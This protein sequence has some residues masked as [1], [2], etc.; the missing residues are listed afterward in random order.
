[1]KQ[2]FFLPALCAWALCGCGRK[3]TAASAPQPTPEQAAQ[4]EAQYILPSQEPAATPANPATPQPQPGQRPQPAQL[5]I[6]Q[7][8]NGAI[9]APLT[10][11]LRQFIEKNGRVPD[12]FSEF[13]NSAMDSVPLAPDGMKFVI[14]PADRT[15]KAVKK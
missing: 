7:R 11:K 2:L 9:H 5:P 8:L 13:A 1:M 12:S 10:I 15:V 3:E 14:D 6:Q 4:I